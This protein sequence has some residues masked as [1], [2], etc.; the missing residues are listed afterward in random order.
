MKFLFNYLCIAV[1]C[2]F[3]S[4]FLI[5]N[6]AVLARGA[7][8]DP[9]KMLWDFSFS[10]QIQPN[11]IEVS[12]LSQTQL[13]LQFNSPYNPALASQS[14]RYKINGRA[15]REIVLN[16]NGVELILEL[17]TPLYASVLLN[18]DGALLSNSDSNP[19]IYQRLF[20][21]GISEI[22][23]KNDKELI[24]FH[25]FELDSF[26][27][28]ISDF[29]LVD[30][31]NTIASAIEVKSN[32]IYL[33]FSQALHE[34]QEYLLAIPTR[35]T[36][37]GKFLP[38]TTHSI[39]FNTSKNEFIR[40][41][42]LRED[43]IKLTFSHPLDQVFALIPESYSLDGMHP[44]YVEVENSNYSVVLN[45]ILVRE[46]SDKA[47][48]IKVDGLYDESGVNYF[49]ETRI[50]PSNRSKD[51]PEFRSVVINEV[52]AA[53]RANNSLPNVEYIELY[54][55][56]N[57]SIDLTGFVLH[58]SRRNTILPEFVLDAK[59]YVILSPRNQASQFQPYGET[60]GLTNWP[61]LLNAGDRVLLTNPEGIPI[62]S[63]RYTTASY[64][65]SIYAQGGY[66]LE[67][68]NPYTLCQ[69]STNIKSS[70][71]PLR[72][73]PGSVNSVYDP[74]PDRIA[75]KFVNSEVVQ[76]NQAVLYF[77]KI[78]QPP[79][80]QLKIEVSPALNAT[81]I[82]LDQT[83]TALII[84]FDSEIRG[85]TNYN[86][87]LTNL[88]D[89]AGNLYTDQEAYIVLP[90][91][92]EAGDVV[93]SE[94]LF[95]PRIGAP[96]FVE[97]YNTSAKHLS[98]KD[99]KLANLNNDGEIA[100]RRILFSE[101]K[102]LEPYAFMV[103]TTD[104]EGLYQ[105]YPKGEPTRF[106][107]YS[108][109][110][111]YP[112]NSG[113][114]VFLN[115]DESLMEVFSYSDNMHHGLLRE[116]KGVSL[117]RLSYNVEVNNPA[118][119]QS[120]SASAGFATPG[121]R[122]SQNF[123]GNSDFGIEISPKVFVPDGPGEAN[124][125]K[126]GYKMVQSGQVGTINIYSVDGQLIRQLC[127]NAIW[128]EEGFYIWDGTFSNGSKVRPGYYLVWVEIFGL[129]GNVRQIKKTVVVGTK[130]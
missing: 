113:N 66:S 59:G 92:A 5:I 96:K 79:N 45:G 126:I 80:S 6:A 117:E 98:L 43:A 60:L 120:A 95:N 18:V 42:V 34:G 85:G 8:L 88:R 106:E 17:S 39:I 104:A 76:T 38:A 82:A 107:A 52:M 23:S 47:S 61:T 84:T 32:R 15:P 67:L 127:Q 77:S 87:K 86:I 103:F 2:C 1:F 22:V 68:I 123:D 50:K 54:N 110:P 105:E 71:S 111:S 55:T 109:L 114:V 83:N 116:T 129:D 9:P 58:N 25:H 37:T 101:E 26:N 49:I 57:K 70:E 19:F 4:I 78:L 115:P 7:H 14:S 20:E 64:G 121:Y 10:Q 56:T 16:E 46:N 27:I 11:F 73:T 41:E 125:V 118:N 24:I 102:L 53:P 72:G 65:G 28:S 93:L 35:K 99:W 119:W 51:E 122:N 124:I 29:T 21:D 13:L 75:P 33:Q 40:A 62:D 89:C 74:T 30:N 36:T 130:F 94:V 48:L 63:L 69:S 81:Q 44:D 31:E 12:V 100:N 97:I 90:G 91:T 112:I 128:G 108:S 3:G